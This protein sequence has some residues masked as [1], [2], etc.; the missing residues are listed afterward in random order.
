MR[1]LLADN[2]VAGIGQDLWTAFHEFQIGKKLEELPVCRN[3]LGLYHPFFWKHEIIYQR[4]PARHLHLRSSLFDG[5]REGVGKSQLVRMAV[6]HHRKGID[7]P[8]VRVLI[9]DLILLHHVTA[10]D[11][12]K[13][14]THRQP[15]R[16]DG[17]V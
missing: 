17:G 9:L 12:H 10:D 15:H 14:Q 3:N 11:N 6:L 8:P 1:K 4:Q 7:V 2:H 16:L 13:R 5:I